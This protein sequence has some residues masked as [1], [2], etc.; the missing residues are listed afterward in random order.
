[1]KSVKKWLF[2][3]AFLGDLFEASTLFPAHSSAI[4]PP[5]RF[6][7]QQK[8][9]HLASRSLANLAVQSLPIHHRVLILQSI[10][11]VP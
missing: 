6:A 1:M 5:P 2:F 11:S 10:V 7:L 9:Q 3:V 4:S 8:Q